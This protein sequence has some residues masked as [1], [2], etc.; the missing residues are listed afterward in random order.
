ML[1]EKVAAANGFT[2]YKQYGESEAAH[3][4]QVDVSTLKRWR[5]EG[6][7]PYVNLGERHVR[8]LGIMIADC[9][10]GVHNAKIQPK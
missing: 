7:V 2:L 10:L 4:L 9:M 1:R 5:R 8:Y 6:K 3:F